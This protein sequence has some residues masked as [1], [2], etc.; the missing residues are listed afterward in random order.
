MRKEF[1]CIV[2]PVSCNL[3]VED[4]EGQ[5]TV[6]ENQCKRGLVFG[7]NEF[8]NPKRMLTTT[9]KITGSSVKRLPVISV[10]EVPKDRLIELAELLYKLTVN[11]PI[12]RGDIVAKNIGN[13]GVDVIATR[14]IK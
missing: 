6:H 14:T 8:R 2:C 11:S 5:L 9:V 1:T 7:E 10:D 3:V 12:Y 4:K 13:T